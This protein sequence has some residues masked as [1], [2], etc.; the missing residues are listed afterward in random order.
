MCWPQSSGEILFNGESFKDFYPERSAAYVDQV[1][2]TGSHKLSAS[3]CQV[4]TC[5]ASAIAAS[6]G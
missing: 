6:S 1:L 3:K 4:C 2:P 5:T